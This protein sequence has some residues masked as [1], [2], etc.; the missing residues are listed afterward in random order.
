MIDGRKISVVCGVKDRRDHLTTSLSTWLA[1]L[2][3]DEVVIV[4]WSS[5]EP[6]TQF[7][8]LRVADPWVA[9]SRVVDSR[10]ADHRV[11]VV[12]VS[13]QAHWHASKCHNLEVRLATGDLVLRIDADDL[14]S[15]SFFRLHTLRESEFWCVDQSVR[16]RS[17][18]EMH[19]S[20]VIYARKSDFLRVGGYSE[21][22]VTYGH[23]DD[24]LVDRLR[25]LGLQSRYLNL[26]SMRHIPHSD[27][28][29][30]V[31]QDLGDIVGER[32]AYASWT[33]NLGAVQRSAAANR[34][35]ARLSPW[36]PERGDRAAAW[37][38]AWSGWRGEAREVRVPS[39]L[40]KEIAPDGIAHSYPGTSVVCGYR[41]RSESLRISARG[42]SYDPE[43]SE[44]VVVDWSS[45][46]GEAS[47]AEEICE[48]LYTPN[49][50]TGAFP[51]VVLARVEGEGTWQP[52]PCFNLCLGLA[53]REKVLKLDADIAFVLD[54]EPVPGNGLPFFA[55]HRLAPG[56]FYAGDWRGARDD[57][58]RHLSG[59]VYAWRTD[60]LDA[61]GWCERIVTY[62][63]DDCDLYLRLSLRGL[64]RRGLNRD[65]L[66]HFQ[67]SDA[68]RL[69]SQ[70]GRIVSCFQEAE[71]NRHLSESDPWKSDDA[72]IRWDVRKRLTGGKVEVYDCRRK[73]TS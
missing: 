2:A 64:E 59:V 30:V 58:E 7:L 17:D 15:E 5:R 39:T 60:L 25:A 1:C 38:V 55:C 49:V 71:F 57:N 42:W 72:V 11:R 27:G 31:N 10:V 67:H 32:P 62:G 34:H 66:Y 37:N 24:D 6:V 33:W 19:L 44:I 68:I 65:T 73:V 45:R 8:D 56:F 48:M 20:G 9:D 47:V 3:V 18:D 70:P 12:R 61:C 41:D 36:S 26:D 51:R 50:R 43:V 21:R 46:N 16:F 63:Y 29:R 53:T 35:A 22:L 23:E 54:P 13:G 28:D 69:Q 4:D 14:L 52:G 40:W